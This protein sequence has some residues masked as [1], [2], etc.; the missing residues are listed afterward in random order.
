ME[1]RKMELVNRNFYRRSPY[2]CKVRFGAGG[3][4]RWGENHCWTGQPL[5]CTAPGHRRAG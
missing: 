5:L 2:L 1:G 3:G 4:G